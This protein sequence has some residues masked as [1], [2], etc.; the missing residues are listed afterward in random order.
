MKSPATSAANHTELELLYTS[1]TAT[2]ARF[3]SISEPRLLHFI[4]SSVLIRDT[5]VAE[6]M[7]VANIALS[8]DRIRRKRRYETH[9]EKKAKQLK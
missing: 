6:Q 3:Q 1:Q 8:R 5:H 4:R 7:T 9:N 2:E